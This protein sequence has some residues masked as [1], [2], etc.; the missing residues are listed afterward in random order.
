MSQSNQIIYLSAAICRF[1]LH[2]ILKIQ[3]TEFKIYNRT[4][5]SPHQCTAAQGGRWPVNICLLLFPKNKIYVQFYYNN[6]CYDSE[7][8][9][10]I[11]IFLNIWKCPVSQLNTTIFLFNIMNIKNFKT[12]RVRFPLGT[13][14]FLYML[15][16]SPLRK[17]FK[18]SKIGYIIFG[19][20]G[21]F[22]LYGNNSQFYWGII[23]NQ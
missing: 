10:I 11:K 12:K 21:I 7:N 23:Y 22:F 5:V 6:K 15:K 19:E 14:W 2:K 16:S 20:K 8:L 9:G 18:Y 13:P 1:N 17:Y 3:S 4:Q